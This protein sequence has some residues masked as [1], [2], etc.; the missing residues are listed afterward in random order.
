MALIVPSPFKSPLAGHCRPVISRAL[1]WRIKAAST[2]SV[3]LSQFTSPGGAV[4]PGDRVLVIGLGPVGQITAR[5]ALACGASVAGTDL[6]PWRLQ[7]AAEK[8][9]VTARA[10]EEGAE[11]LRD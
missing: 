5:L 3:T 1:N 6:D 8:G 11:I 10:G 4:A 7:V 9:V 2:G